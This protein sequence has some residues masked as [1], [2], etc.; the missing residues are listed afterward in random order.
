MT[1]PALQW[2]PTNAPVASSRT[3][4]IWD[5]FADYVRNLSDEAESRIAFVTP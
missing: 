1:T 5:R 4:D 2:R 3:D